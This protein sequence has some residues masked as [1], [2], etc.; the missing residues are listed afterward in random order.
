MSD[1]AP[2]TNP[3]S[4][5]TRER[6][7]DA[8]ERLF[9]EHGFRSASVRD[10]TREGECNIASVNYHFGGKANLYREVF[11]RRLRD[12]RQKRLDGIDR[13]LSRAGEGATLELLLSTFT[14]AF[15][16]PLV[17]ESSGRLWMLLF[18]QEMID[19]QLP[20][21]TLRAEMFEP[22]QKA[23]SEAFMQV[24]P[25]LARMD[26]E[27][28]SQSLMGQLVHVVKLQ[29]CLVGTKDQERWQLPEL[30]E[31]TLRFSAAGIRA[32]QAVAA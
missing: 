21:E 32:L 19:P 1:R 12:L 27:L 11:L 13:A 31:H 9:A 17:T 23:L 28:C 22:V 4:A 20:A 2:N 25:G 18:S 10:I 24:C 6:L 15:V 14:S 29:R 7:L 16:E 8:A 5:Q 3:D 30:V 26:A